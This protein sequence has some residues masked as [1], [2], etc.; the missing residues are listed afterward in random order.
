VGSIA[1]RAGR[2][3]HLGGR[4]LKAEQL[5]AARST[6]DAAGFDLRGG[7]RYGLGI[8]TFT[9]RCGGF[10]WTHGGNAPGYTTVTGTTDDGR[11]ATIAVTAMPTSLESA[12]LLDTAL[13][14]HEDGAPPVGRSAVGLRL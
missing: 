1:W 10:A 6:V 7:S 3:R 14:A 13:C 8:G 11:S 9:L 2:R 5:R 4:L 12:Q